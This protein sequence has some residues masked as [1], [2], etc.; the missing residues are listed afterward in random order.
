[1]PLFGF[2]R[3]LLYHS[4][5]TP[6]PR[7]TM[8]C[9]DVLQFN[10]IRPEMG[11]HIKNNQSLRRRKANHCGN[12]IAIRIA[13]RGVVRGQ[14]AFFANGVGIINFPISGADNGLFI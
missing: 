3:Q 14:L 7:P 4:P 1:M 8:T 13:P 6:K 9:V 11:L 10:A 2:K 12:G 5:T